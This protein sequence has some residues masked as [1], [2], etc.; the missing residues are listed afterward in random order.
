MSDR[1]TVRIVLHD[2]D[3]KAIREGRMDFG[4]ALELV[5]NHRHNYE[6][7]EVEEEFDKEGAVTA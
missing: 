4:T 3:L 5:L 2:G 6:I 1:V 7:I